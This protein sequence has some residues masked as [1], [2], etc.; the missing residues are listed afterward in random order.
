MVDTGTAAAQDIRARLQGAATGAADGLR[1]GLWLSF[2]DPY[3][4]EV[5]IGCGVDWVGVDLQHGNLEPHH[6]PGLLRVAESAGLPLLARAPSHDPAILGRILDA[7]VEGLIIPMVESAEQAH[8]LVRATRP[9]PQ[10]TR[11]T[12][13]CRSALGVT[14]A[15][16]Q[17]L[18]LPM[19]ET[20]TGLDHAAEIL[21]VPG[22][23]GVF[24]GPYDL[25][26]SAG[27]P[28]PSSPQT[29]DALRDVLRL[30][31]SV[32]K[33]GGFMAG[34]PELRAMASEADLVAVETDVSALRLG[35]ARVFE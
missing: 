3:G 23:D 33:I 10:G 12:G 16:A 22:V 24:V 6:L 13:G 34:R 7:G 21:A 20:A 31:R 18:L 28:A 25:T 30:A 2:L 27:F 14:R 9:P 35:L 11:S 17:Q 26:I 4:L 5:A 1:Q 29:V 15:P 8:A 19:V 32:G